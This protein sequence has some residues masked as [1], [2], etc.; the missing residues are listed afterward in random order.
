[1]IT[2]G[3]LKEVLDYDPETGEFCWRVTLSRR[4]MAGKRAGATSPS[5]LFR[6]IGIDGVRHMAHRLA[7]LYAYGTFPIGHLDHINRNKSDN[8]I[9][10]LRKATKIENG[11]NSKARKSRSGLK[12]AHWHEGAKK[13]TSDIHH[14]GKKIYLGLF[15]TAKE[16]HA[17]YCQAAKEHFGEFWN[18]GISAGS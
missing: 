16:A 14:N 18:S 2:Q 13:W 7:W 10:N 9:K 17:A 4:A 6:L 8:R 1:M 12:G 5:V 11:G 15:G 3:R